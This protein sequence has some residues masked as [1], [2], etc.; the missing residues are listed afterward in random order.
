MKTIRDINKLLKE[1]TI[2]LKLSFWEKARIKKVEFDSENKR[3]WNKVYDFWAFYLMYDCNW[4]EN[5]SEWI[6]YWINKNEWIEKIYND[7][8]KIIN[9]WV[10]TISL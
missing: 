1:N 9:I 3:F 5:I 8:Q 7:F 2:Y 4:V 10:D 6:L